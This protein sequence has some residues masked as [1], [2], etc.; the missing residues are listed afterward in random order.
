[1]GF[2]SSEVAL[3]IFQLNHSISERYIPSPVS[4]EFRRSSSFLSASLSFFVRLSETDSFCFFDKRAYVAFALFIISRCASVILLGIASIAEI[5]ASTLVYGLLSVVTG[6]VVCGAFVVVGDS[7][8]LLTVTVGFSCLHEARSPQAML[9]KQSM[10]MHLTV[11]FLS[12][13][14]ISISSLINKAN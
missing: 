8:V 2:L 10:L 4:A 13:S 1:M 6:A 11:V 14:L 12:L 7:V 3:Y 5:T 9:H